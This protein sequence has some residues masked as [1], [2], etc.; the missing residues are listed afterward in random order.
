MPRKLVLLAATT[1]L[2]LAPFAA[3]AQQATSMT[4]VASPPASAAPL[5]APTPAMRSVT[6]PALEKPRAPPHK[7]SAAER[8]AAER[9][10]P[11]ARAAFWSHEVELDPTDTVAGVRLASA[12]R[13]LGQNGEAISAASRVLVVDPNNF[14]ALMETAKAYVAAGQGFYAIDPLKQASLAKPR[15]WR[16]LSLLGVAYVQV[17][18]DDD[19][20][21]IWREALAL[22]P[23]NPAVLSNQAMDMAAK[24]DAPGAEALL[25]R[26]V[27]R[28]GSGLL[29]RQNLVLVLGL[30]GKLGEAEKML[31]E[32][33]P[34]EQANADLAYLQSLTK[35][36]AAV[37]APN[38][39]T[40]AAVKGAG[41]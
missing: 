23:D 15:D 28:P 36:K 10:E 39:R 20:Q 5:T 32:D 40:W 24:G 4:P 25:R 16:P 35:T 21:S 8:D 33:L 3:G 37:P 11:L 19:A 18:R 27:A 29:E 17:Q 22:S 1:A 14:D 26:A 31:R 2:T 12:L 41:S 38:A 9:M 13:A 34:P 6:Q 7:A 30:Q